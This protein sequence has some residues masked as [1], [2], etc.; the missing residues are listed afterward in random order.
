M[1]D[2]KDDGNAETVVMTEDP[3][4]YEDLSDCRNGW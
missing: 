1:A 3:E 4:W 2:E